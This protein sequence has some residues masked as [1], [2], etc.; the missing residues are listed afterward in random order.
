VNEEF[1]FEEL[2]EKNWSS[3]LIDVGTDE[4]VE[5]EESSLDN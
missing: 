4:R 3:T 5:I 2:F 1:M